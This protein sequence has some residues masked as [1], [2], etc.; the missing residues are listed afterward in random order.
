MYDDEVVEIITPS[1]Y[2]TRMTPE[3]LGYTSRVIEC[4]NYL[5]S[6]GWRICPGIVREIAETYDYPMPI[7]RDVAKHLARCQY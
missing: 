2:L 7:A 4:A 3:S 1:Y 6:M 5:Y